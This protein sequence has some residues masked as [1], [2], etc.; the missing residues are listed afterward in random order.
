MR[1]KRKV[2]EEEEKGNV[3]RKKVEDAVGNKMSWNAIIYLCIH[4]II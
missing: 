4:N 3:Q 1:E 2:K